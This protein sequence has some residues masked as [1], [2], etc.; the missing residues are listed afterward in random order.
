M[1]N[2]LGAFQEFTGPLLFQ[3]V[4]LYVV[5]LSAFVLDFLV[6]EPRRFH[7]LAGFGKLAELTEKHFYGGRVM[8]VLATLVVVAPFVVLTGYVYVL[9]PVTTSVFMLYFTLGAHSLS[10]HAESVSE[11]LKNGEL[12][13]ARRHTGMIVSRDTK[14][15]DETGLSKAT[16]ESVLENG[17]DAIFGAL[18]WF[19][20]GGP[21]GVLCFRLL[22]T[23]DAMWGY[24]N[25]RYLKFG[26]ACARLDDVMNFIPARLTA[27]SYAFA[28]SFR[29]A[30]RAWNR[31]AGTWKSPNA[32]PVMASGAG[33]LELSLGG[34]AV[35]GAR[36]EERQVLG[37]GPEPDGRDINR[38]LSLLRRALLVWFV[39]IIPCLI[40]ISIFFREV[41]FA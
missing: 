4:V 9:F 30:L 32:G 15:L 19:I 1:E 22:N 41:L 26:W 28:G 11:A 2:W 31:Q 8:G 36:T 12:S 39:I 5:I 33:S 21:A 23:L 18:F 6:G 37:G 13:E 10:I 20:I 27:L 3:A 17:N 24:R 40:F 25:E 35:Y 34:S 16:I 14:D 29:S 38:S 7:P